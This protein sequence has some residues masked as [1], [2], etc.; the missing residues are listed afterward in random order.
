MALLTPQDVA[1]RS[2]GAVD[3]NDERLPTYIGD[4]VARAQV[5]A[6]CLLRADLPTHKAAA[7][8]SILAEA[9][10]RRVDRDD[11]PGPEFQS[12]T[13]TAGPFG[14]TTNYGSGGRPP[15]TRADEAELAALCRG[16]RPPRT[17]RVRPS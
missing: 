6:P 13:E 12:Q 16:N 1:R 3:G 11:N 9:V 10:L 2:H 4:V 8:K 7:A 15:L 17:I 5:V 14:R